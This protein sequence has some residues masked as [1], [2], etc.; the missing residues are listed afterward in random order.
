[1]LGRL[2]DLS[3]ALVPG[4]PVTP[5]LSL[6]PLSKFFA[7]SRTWLDETAPRTGCVVTHTL[8]IDFSRWGG[9]KRAD[10]LSSLLNKPNRINGFQSFELPLAFDQCEPTFDPWPD[11]S[12]TGALSDFI[13]K[14]FGDGRH[15]I[16]WFDCPAPESVAWSLCNFSWGAL[17]KRLSLCTLCLQPRTVRDRSF[18]VMF[19][20]TAARPRFNSFPSHCFVNGKPKLTPVDEKWV[21]QVTHYFANPIN[22]PLQGALDLVGEYSEPDPTMVRNLFLLQDL[23]SRIDK[24]PTA[25][26]ALLDVLE[27]FD[28]SD[29][30]LASLRK[31]IVHATLQ[32][33]GTRAPDEAFS[34]L[35][36]LDERIARRVEHPSV[37]EFD[38]LRSFVGAL[39]RQ[40]PSNALS[41]IASRSNFEY[42]SGR[43]AF[44]EGLFDGLI[45]STT[46][47]VLELH[48]LPDLG[49]LAVR[50]RPEI[51]LRY[52]AAARAEGESGSDQV[53]T[54]I[55]S[56]AS[57]ND[58]S[59]LRDALLPCVTTDEDSRL[60]SELLND[61][62]SEEVTAALDTLAT[63][64]RGF[65]SLKL[66]TLCIERL[67][68]PHP[69]EVRSWAS[70]T[71]H[72]SIGS[73][74]ITSATYSFDATGVREL[75]GDWP[76]GQRGAE[77]VA[78]YIQRI[79]ASS[80]AAFFRDHVRSDC[81]FL[82]SLLSTVNPT[83][84]SVTD[85]VNLAFRECSD[86]PV[87]RY[88]ELVPLLGHFIETSAQPVVV[89]S[90]AIS[91]IKEYVYDRIDED[92]LLKWQA[93]SWYS[94]W[95]NQL[96]PRRVEEMIGWIIR[97]TDSWHRCWK[98]LTIAPPAIYGPPGNLIAATKAL[99]YSRR[100]Y[101]TAAT[102]NNWVTVIRRARREST[103][104]DC[105]YV[106]AESLQFAFNHNWL[107]ISLVAVE[108]F[109]DI[110][111]I[112]SSGNQPNEVACLFG[113]ATWDKAKELRTRI[114]DSYYQSNAWP[115]GDLAIAAASDFLLRKLF[116]RLNRRWHG[117]RFV[118]AMID[119]LRS[120]ADGAGS[121]AIPSLEAFLHDPDFDEPW[122]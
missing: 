90:S 3:G 64:T 30:S 57:D 50:T 8:L 14:F 10:R 15:P 18:H 98:W 62:R 34:T 46:D 78:S 19:A 73:A 105:V 122:D 115:P 104:S 91:A 81:S 109:A 97:D 93:S 60:A 7:V 29:E 85:A 32:H 92:K 110:H 102:A 99:V 69:T 11:T 44:V 48:Q 20:P 71:P 76:G 84:D 100:S 12:G 72:W 61:V 4:V 74:D 106:L 107:P 68:I 82:V 43:S 52:L 58:R 86:M 121:W 35:L 16:V 24:S 6:F 17:R 1:V 89:D 27:T 116:K 63:A 25:G 95:C 22:N 94:Q 87:A 101:F 67:S 112:V 75:L 59:K 80:K 31:S 118:R 13:A 9:L 45:Q 36:L 40:H 83:S 77:V 65:R 88:A 96:S 33:L 111:G 66:R 28:P 47:A 120:R 23:W 42:G 21:S 39:S 51:L 26:V 79:L 119:D 70:T 54:W 37:T 55:A 114:V 56:S 103:E 49:R 38:L 53:A 108:S 41:G 117:E 5:Y 113:M 2:S